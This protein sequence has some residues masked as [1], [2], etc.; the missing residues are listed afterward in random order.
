MCAEPAATAGDGHQKTLS[1]RA[2]MA[3]RRSQE[4][5]STDRRLEKV[6]ERRKTLKCTICPPHKGENSSRKPK[7]GAQKPRYKTTRK[8]RG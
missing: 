8:G 5:L 7:H 1:G 4:K 2:V 6:K 3:L